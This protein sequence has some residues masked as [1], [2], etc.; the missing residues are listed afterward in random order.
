MDNYE[1]EDVEV[2]EEEDV[3]KIKSKRALRRHH[4][5]RMKN[6]TRDR[7][8][9]NWLLIDREPPDKVVG[10]Q[11]TTKCLCSG[12]C[13]GNPRKHFNRKTTQELKKDLDYKEWLCYEQ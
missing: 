12:H 1:D 7:I 11:A 5:D 9:R 10:I 2:E 13:C 4:R 8:K 6:K 3:F